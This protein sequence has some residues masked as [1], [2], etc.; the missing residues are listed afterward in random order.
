M[1]V[2]NETSSVM[3][4]KLTNWFG[5]F[6]G[7]AI[8]AAGL[9]LLVAQAAMLNR[10]LWIFGLVALVLGA[11]VAVS[12][13]F[14]T[15]TLDRNRQMVT[16]VSRRIVGGSALRNIEF[17][18]I[19]EIIVEQTFARTTAG[20]R[21]PRV[22]PIYN[23]IFHM[24]DGRM[25]PIDITPRRSTTINGISMTRFVQN[26]AV[27]EIGNKVAEF[28]GVPCVDRRPPTFAQAIEGI[29]KIIRTAKE[30]TK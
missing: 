3:E 14:V 10:N 5:V 24:T 6:F 15:L 30:Q 17:S 9:A 25:E 7:A 28:I 4:L 29:Q 16:I 23:L 12:Q 26:N 11:I 18:R 1:K 19:K 8:S 27:M 2:A 13:R 21:E 22:R 20:S